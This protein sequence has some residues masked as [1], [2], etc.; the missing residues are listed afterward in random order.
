MITHVGSERASLIAY[1][2][3]KTTAAQ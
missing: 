3:S 1:L 2:L